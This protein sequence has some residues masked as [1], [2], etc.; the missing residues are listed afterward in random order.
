MTPNE[1]HTILK[2]KI[3]QRLSEEK[4]EHTDLYEKLT[5]YFTSGNTKGLLLVGSVGVGKTKAMDIYREILREHGLGF[6]SISTRH[7]R[8]EYA[9][10]GG[11][12]IDKYGR[13]SFG[14]KAGNLD[15]TRPVTWCF[16]DLGLEEQNAKN[17]GNDSNVMAEILLDRYEHFINHGMKTHATTNLD[18]DNLGKLYGDRMRDRMREMFEVITITGE[19]FR[20]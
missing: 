17:Y 3:T 6:R 15:K 19:S 12:T 11:Q 20:K 5:E 7:L 2:S 18:A 16:D 8:R 14:R 10:D 4:L 9:Q 1:A 13:N